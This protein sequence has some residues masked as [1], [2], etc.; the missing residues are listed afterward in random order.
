MK[1]RL[2]AIIDAATKKKRL[3]VRILL[4]AVGVFTMGF[5]MSVIEKLGFGTDPYTC[6]NNGLSLHTGISLG[7][8][9]LIV[10]GVIAVF[11]LIFGAEKIGLGTLFNMVGFGYSI[12]LFRLIW[13]SAGLESIALSTPIRL[14]LVIIMLFIFILAVSLYLAADLGC[15][16]YDA[17]PEIICERSKL[18]CRTVRT[19]WDISAVIIG[20]LLGSEVGLTTLVCAFGVGSAASFVK[21]KLSIW[22]DR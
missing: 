19:L 10:S 8:W 7:T 1:N 15:A 16:P 4:S 20:A 6:L 17:A 22:L 13:R 3:R 2:K 5:G 11:V 9:G 18:S 21:A 14:L 12:D